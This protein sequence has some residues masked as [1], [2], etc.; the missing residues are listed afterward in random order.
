LRAAKDDMLS[1]LRPRNVLRDALD[2]VLK[3]PRDDVFREY[4]GDRI[5]IVVGAVLAFFFVSTVCSIDLMFRVAHL[6]SDSPLWLKGFALI[7][8]AVVW[9]GGLLA[10][11]YVFLIWLEGRAAQRHREEQGIEIK[12][13][14]GFLAY[15]KYSRAL[16]PWIVV[17]A[18][19]VLPLLIMA[20]RAPMV[21]LALAALAIAAP[22]VFK[23]LDR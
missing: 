3:L 1:Q 16:P 13:P 17:L 8:G 2:L 12:V 19:V 18:C 11:T 22:L 9:A 7:V 10:Q 6:V 5:W 21:A 15:L 23:K 4:V 14:H 20:R